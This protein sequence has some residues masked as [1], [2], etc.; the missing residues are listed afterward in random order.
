MAVLPAK[1]AY[2]SDH[3]GIMKGKLNG[4]MATLIPY[5]SESVDIRDLMLG[6]DTYQWLVYCM[7]FGRVM[8]VMDP[9]HLV[10]HCAC[11]F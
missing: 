9:T 11:C 2:G 5:I 4:Q 1:M 6:T 8:E 10:G 3:I 7:D